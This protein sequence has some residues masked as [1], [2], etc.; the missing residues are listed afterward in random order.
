MTTYFTFDGAA[1]K[2]VEYPT[3]FRV[4]ILNYFGYD[5]VWVIR[6]VGD[7]Y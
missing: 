7:N 4:G 2:T 3:G 5:F 1:R 6:I